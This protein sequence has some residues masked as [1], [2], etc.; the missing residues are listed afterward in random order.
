MLILLLCFSPGFLPWQHQQPVF[1]S[2]L[3]PPLLLTWSSL[4]NIHS[5]SLRML[6][7]LFCFLPGSLP[8]SIR[9]Q[10]S[11]VL[12]FLL[13]SLPGPLLCSIHSQS[14]RVLF[15]F[16]CFLPG[17]LHCKHR[18]QLPR[19]HFFLL[20]FCLVIS[21]AILVAMCGEHSSFSLVLGCF[22]PLHHWQPV[23]ESGILP[24]LVYGSM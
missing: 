13:C 24:P 2:T 9:S 19:V 3:L 4:S 8:G 1:K 16:I 14:P 5:L 21:M 7:F 20:C 15:F 23:A 12:F 11:T 17:S 18:G 22:F 10:S 6:S